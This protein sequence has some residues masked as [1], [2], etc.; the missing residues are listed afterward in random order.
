VAAPTFGRIAEV[1]AQCLGL[2]AAPDADAGERP[3]ALAAARVA[4]MRPAP[5]SAP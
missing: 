3:A 4:A 5:G 1:T 2:P